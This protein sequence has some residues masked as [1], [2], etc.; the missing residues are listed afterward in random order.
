[1]LLRTPLVQ[2]MLLIVGL[3]VTSFLPI[4]GLAAALAEVR[5]LLLMVLGVAIMYAGVL[6]RRGEPG[7]LRQRVTPEALN[8]RVR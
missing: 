7:L 3:I 5:L 4:V 8:A 1:M 2:I 6:Q